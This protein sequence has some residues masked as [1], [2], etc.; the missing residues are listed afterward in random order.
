MNIREL[1]LQHG[2]DISDQEVLKRVQEQIGATGIRHEDIQSLTV[3]VKDYQMGSKDSEGAPQVTDLRSIS[4]KVTTYSQAGL[5][6]PESTARP[7]KI[8]TPDYEPSQRGDKKVCVVLPDPQIGFRDLNGKLDPFHDERA[9]S[10]ALK[11]MWYLEKKYGV[12]L[13]INLGDFLDLP[14]HSKYVQEPTWQQ[15]TQ[16]AIDRGHA[17]LAEQR[18]VAPNAEIRLIEGNHDLRLTKAIMAKMPESWNIR[19]AEGKY[20]VM[21]VPHLLEIDRLGVVYVDAYPAGRTW[22]N[23]R[24]CCVHG[25][26]VNSSGSTAAKVLREERT[27]VIF[28]HVHRLESH[29]ATVPV[30]NGRRIY[31]AVSP[32]CLCR[33]DGAVPGYASGIDIFGKPAESVPNWQQGMAVVFYEDGDSPFRINTLFI[34]NGKTEFEGMWFE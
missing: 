24:L 33:I 14:A 2:Y 25:Y 31:A 5:Y 18:A 10:V 20:P 11:V 16:A 30:R 6:V 8:T 1:L 26:K 12:D 21:S 32:G 3:Q 23:D 4:V 7:V 19:Q 27:S 17:F 29:M 9:M 13:V 34:D 15:T 22:I 28:G